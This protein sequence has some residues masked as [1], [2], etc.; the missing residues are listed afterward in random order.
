MAPLILAP[1]YRLAQK[2]SESSR[3]HRTQPDRV[4][5]LDLQDHA[6]LPLK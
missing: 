5:V 4:R 6:T 1:E 2:L 3:V